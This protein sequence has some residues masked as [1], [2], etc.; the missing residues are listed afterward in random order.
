M[1]CSQE[2]SVCVCVSQQQGQNYLPHESNNSPP[3][4]S[5][6]DVCLRMKAILTFSSILPQLF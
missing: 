6:K 3:V 1:C 5:D 2:M 4:V